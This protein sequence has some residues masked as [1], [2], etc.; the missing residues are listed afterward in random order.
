MPPETEL[1]ILPDPLERAF[2]YLSRHYSPDVLST[3]RPTG[4]G[5]E[6]RVVLAD[7]GGAGRQDVV[8]LDCWIM[9]E[10][11]HTDSEQ[12][13]LHARRVE[14]LMR[15]WPW[16]EGGVAHYRVLGRPVL[17]TVLDREGLTCYTQT[18]AYRMRGQTEILH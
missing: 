5:E 7:V 4:A 15:Q 13:S 9:I 2:K 8:W 1:V 16:V 12:A 6:F 14:A 3:L 17:E 18:V 10:V 11:Y